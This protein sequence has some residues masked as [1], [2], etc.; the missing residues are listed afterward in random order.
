M[1]KDELR[2]LA[3]LGSVN[4]VKAGTAISFVRSLPIND[5]RFAIPFEGRAKAAIGF[6]LSEKEKAKLGELM[7]RNHDAGT[8]MTR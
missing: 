1:T 7:T 3:L 2:V 5:L 8:G 4:S 6:W